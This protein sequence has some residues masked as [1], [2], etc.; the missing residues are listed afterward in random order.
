MRV[1]GEIGTIE[2]DALPEGMSAEE[3]RAAVA[4]ALEAQIRAGGAPGA[5]PSGSR[6]GEGTRVAVGKAGGLGI[7]VA[8][9]I[10]EGL[11]R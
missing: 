11:A 3:L 4:G 10:Y 1:E 2:I 9:A 8:A 7:E 5:P 6:A